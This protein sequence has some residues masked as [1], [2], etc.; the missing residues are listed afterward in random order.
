MGG[1]IQG[2]SLKDVIPKLHKRQFCD[3]ALYG[4][5]RGQLALL[6]NVTIEQAI[7]GFYKEFN[8]TEDDLSRQT[9]R[10]T[11]HRMVKEFYENEKSEGA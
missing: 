7:T 4:F 3:V 8:I 9:C 2:K 10:T 11:Y 6:P 5:I 1:D